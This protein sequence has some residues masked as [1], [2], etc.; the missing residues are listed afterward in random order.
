MWDSKVD[1]SAWGPS[2]CHL[3]LMTHGSEI[4]SLLKQRGRTG[5]SHVSQERTEEDPLY[6]VPQI[7][8][9]KIH[10]AANINYPLQ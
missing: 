4:F 5:Y 6:H 3:F 7:F 10:K 8:G 9:F 1:G 2:F